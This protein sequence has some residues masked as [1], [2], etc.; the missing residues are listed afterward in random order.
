MSTT[1][2]DIVQW[3]RE[4]GAIELALE[5]DSFRAANKGRAARR[6]FGRPFC[7]RVARFEKRAKCHICHSRRLGR[8]A[9]QEELQ[10]TL[11]L[12]DSVLVS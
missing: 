5:L 3:P 9:A 4:A 8:G 11:L 1:I 6:E 2:V 10:T 7:G 12:K